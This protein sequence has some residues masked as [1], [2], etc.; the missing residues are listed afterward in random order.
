[1]SIGVF[2][3]TYANAQSGQMIYGVQLATADTQ[4]FF[5]RYNYVAGTLDTIANLSGIINSAWSTDRYYAIDAFNGRYFWFTREAGPFPNAP[6]RLYTIDLATNTV[7][8]GPAVNENEIGEI[9][10]D[11]YQNKLVFRTVT[12]TTLFK[13]FNIATGSFD[14]L[15]SLTSTFININ[16]IIDRTYNPTTQQYLA[17]TMQGSLPTYGID[18]I[19]GTTGALISTNATPGVYVH[20]VCDPVH[21]KYYGLTNSP[22]VLEINPLNGTSTALTTIPKFYSSLNE[23][24]AVF[25]IASGNFIMPYADSNF[26]NRMAV[27]NVT[28]GSIIADFPA[29]EINH[30]RSGSVYTPLLKTVGNNLAAPYAKTYQWYR[31][32]TLIAGATSQQYVVTTPGSYKT[33]LTFLNGNSMYSAAKNYWPAGISTVQNSPFTV[34]PNPTSNYL[35]VEG[36]NIGCKASIFSMI[37]Q[38]VLSVSDIGPKYIFDLSTLV[39]GTYSLVL[40]DSKGAISK[41]TIIKQ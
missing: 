29:P 22:A 34:Y 38:E 8:T 21:Q 13:T 20:L 41:S 18:V 36:I 11:I 16:G 24:D 14:T 3:S 4:R 10:Y 25:D 40:S 26:N 12:G 23:E 32:D 35:T 31:N 15:S 17:T 37:G 5:V 2:C 7:T 30:S 27:I 9:E 6:F 19:D 39:P 28:S 1:M 33:L